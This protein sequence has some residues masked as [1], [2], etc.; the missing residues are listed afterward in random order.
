MILQVCVSLSLIHI[1]LC[2]VSG[3][4]IRAKHT[5]G[6][7]QHGCDIL[8]YNAEKKQMCIRDSL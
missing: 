1:Y 4:E 2:M 5:D 3:N 7:S 8:Q 6:I